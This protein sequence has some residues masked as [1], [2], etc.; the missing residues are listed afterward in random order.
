MTPVNKD[1]IQQ[2]MLKLSHGDSISDMELGIT[3]SA[4]SLTLDTLKA[5]NRKE[6]A[7][8]TND[9]YHDLEI[10]RGFEAARKEKS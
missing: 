7:L 2:T 6:Y 10:L 9:I 5:I 4:L 8:V 1:I 3:I